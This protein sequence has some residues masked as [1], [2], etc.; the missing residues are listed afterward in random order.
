[1]KRSTDR[2]LTTHTGSLPRPDDLTHMMYD[3]MDG[4][5]VDEVT[6]QKRFHTATAEVVRKQIAAGVDVVD[7]GEYTKV[8]YSTYVT[9]RLTGFEGDSAPVAMAEM[10]DY[11]EYWQRLFSDPAMEGFPHLKT[12]A[13]TAPI[14]LKDAQAVQRDIDNFK[15]A[16][17]GAQPHDAFMSAASPGVISAFLPNRYYP[18]DEAYLAALADAMKPEYE[19]IVNA[20]FA[21]QVD[22]PDLAMSRQMGATAG[23]SVEDF[24]K[25][26]AMHVEALNHALANVPADKLRMHICWGNWEGPHDRDVPLRDVIDVILKAKPSAILIEAANPRHGHEWQVFEE[27][28]LPEGKMIIPGVIDSTSNFVEHPQLV[29][30]RILNYARLVGRENV[31]AGSDC[32]FGTFVGVSNVHPTVM[33][34]KFEAMAEGARLASQQLW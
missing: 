6:L 33:W 28:K 2:I 17:Q 7:D 25:L 21:L 24:R 18:N 29:A 20:G 32:G 3:R 22:C 8:S 13:C 4:K 31:M 1:M 23:K 19:A 5:S 12:P 14:T 15:A 10:Q 11:P 34:K 16:L 9:D 26:A 30:Q 27:V